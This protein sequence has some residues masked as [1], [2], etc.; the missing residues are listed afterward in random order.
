VYSLTRAGRDAPPALPVAAWPEPQSN[1]QDEQD[2]PEPVMPRW[3]EH[4][5]QQELPAGTELERLARE[6]PGRHDLRQ[7]AVLMVESAL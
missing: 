6:Q 3:A 7:E 1:V 2:L 5:E 4:S